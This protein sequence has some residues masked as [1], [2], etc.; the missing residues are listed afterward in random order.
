M[1]ILS[2][3]TLLFI[4]Q[5]AMFECKV[6]NSDNSFYRSESLLSQTK[7]YN[8]KGYSVKEHPS[9]ELGWVSI[10]KNGKS[11]TLEFNCKKK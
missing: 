10:S 11:F 8:R 5:G 3:I 1:N 7:E 6:P 9:K 4:G 2:I